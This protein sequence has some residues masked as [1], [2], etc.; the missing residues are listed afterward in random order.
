MTRRSLTLVGISLL[1]LSVICLPARADSI[2]TFNF[3]TNLVGASGSVSGS[4]T[5]DSTTHVFTAASI[6]FSSSIFGNFS[7]QAPNP[8]NGFL[9]VFGKNVGNTS[10]LYSIVLNPLNLDQFWLSG[11]IWNT[12]G[13]WAGYSYSQVPEG[14]DWFLYL[15]PSATVLLGAVVLAGKQRHALRA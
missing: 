2:S 3:A 4:F 6:T 11:G 8:Q 14:G 13:N 1:F 12:Q 10:F 9:F 5:Y 15:I 7:V